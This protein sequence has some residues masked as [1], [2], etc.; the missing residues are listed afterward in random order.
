[1]PTPPAPSQAR[2]Q[3]LKKYQALTNLSVPMPGDKD[4]RTFLVPRGETVE[5][6]EEQ[7]RNLSTMPGGRPAIRPVKEGS[8]PMPE[9]TGRL[10]SGPIRRPPPPAPGT[11][12]ARPDPPGSSRVAVYHDAPELHEPQLGS[13]NG[14][15]MDALD[16]APGGGV[17]VEGGLTA[18]S[19]R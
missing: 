6:T 3:G 14:L 4:A 9:L 16:I 13:E 5:L 1:M 18:A 11:D 7:A 12:S 15:D 8:E 2:S 19:R 17:H 10:L